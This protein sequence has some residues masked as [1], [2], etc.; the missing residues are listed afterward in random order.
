M[1]SKI[2][3]LIISDT[4]GWRQNQRHDYR[5]MAMK[6]N[7]LA[8]VNLAKSPVQHTIRQWQTTV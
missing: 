2:L 6:S 4:T 7:N 1:K 8:L 5:D 3:S